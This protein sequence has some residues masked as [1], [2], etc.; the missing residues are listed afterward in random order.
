MKDTASASE[1]VQ[2]KLRMLTSSPLR[3]SSCATSHQT[4]PIFVVAWTAS[5]RP[6]HARLAPK[7]P[8]SFRFLPSL[9]FRSTPH[10]FAPSRKL[11]AVVLQCGIRTSSRTKSCQSSPAC[12][13]AKTWRVWL[14]SYAARVG[15]SQASRAACVAASAPWTPRR[16]SL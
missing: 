10:R 16:S 7:V 6:P 14:S 1:E 4:H 8:P 12:A 2:Q 11:F 3:S 5:A 9:S 15:T 13:C